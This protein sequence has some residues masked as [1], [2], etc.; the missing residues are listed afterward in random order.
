MSHPD[1]AISAALMASRTTALA[2]APWP[3]NLS[4]VALPIFPFAPRITYMFAPSQQNHTQLRRPLTQRFSSVGHRLVITG[5]S[6]ADAFSGAQRGGMG[7]KRKH[8]KES[9][10]LRFQDTAHRGGCG[11]PRVVQ[12]NRRPN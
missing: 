9:G 7:S 3:R 6:V 11:K 1:A 8:E 2:G 12:H 4:I 5:V 10:A